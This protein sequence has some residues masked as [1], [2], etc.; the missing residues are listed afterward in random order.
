[1]P[2]TI[3]L[4]SQVPPVLIVWSPWIGLTACPWPC[5]Q[6]R[7]VDKLLNLTQRAKT[8]ISLHTNT[9]E[10]HRLAAATP[11]PCRGPRVSGKGAFFTAV[12][13]VQSQPGWQSVSPLIGLIL[14]SLPEQFIIRIII[15]ITDVSLHSAAPRSTVFSPPAILTRS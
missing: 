6:F 1:M 5:C 14:G 11:P 13:S 4:L 8:A 7:K 2:T 9:L 10:T 3:T 12:S 15:H